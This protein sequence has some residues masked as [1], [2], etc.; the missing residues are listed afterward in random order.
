MPRL[1]GGSAAEQYSTATR[2]SLASASWRRWPP[3]VA[4][5]HLAGWFSRFQRQIRP[6]NARDQEHDQ[7][8]AQA[9]RWKVAPVAAVGPSNRAEQQQDENHQK[10][11]RHLLRLLHGGHASDE[12][13][14]AKRVR[15]EWRHTPSWCVPRD[16]ELLQSTALQSAGKTCPIFVPIQGARRWK[17]RRASGRATRCKARLRNR[18]SGELLLARGARETTSATGWKPNACCRML[19]NRFMRHTYIRW[20]RGCRPRHPLPMW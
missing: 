18:P 5:A 14:S 15:Q 9:C 7:G 19:F 3:V 1:F 10:N 13:A 2:Q 20:A 12:R 4:A 6:V 17:R 8:A 16:G 11:G